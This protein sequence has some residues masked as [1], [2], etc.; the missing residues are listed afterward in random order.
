MNHYASIFPDEV[1]PEDW[2]EMLIEPVPKMV[3]SF[4][5]NGYLYGL[6]IISKYDD[7]WMINSIAKDDGEFTFNM[8]KL[9]LKFIRNHEKII[10]MSTRK[11]S[12][13]NR[14]MDRFVDDGKLSYF[15]KG[16]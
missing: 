13:I 12:T 8:K 10:V 6:I 16:V 2:Y 3:H 15:I 11:E 14:I 1:V 7:A 5:V 4:N 9:L